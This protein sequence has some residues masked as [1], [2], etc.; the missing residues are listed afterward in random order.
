MWVII[1]VIYVAGWIYQF[2][3]QADYQKEDTIFDW[4][5]PGYA[6]GL[7]AYLIYR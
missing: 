5:S 6:R 1:A 2:I 4:S 3:N 7:C